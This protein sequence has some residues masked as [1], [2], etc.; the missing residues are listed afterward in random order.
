MSSVQLPEDVILYI[1]TFNAEHR[2]KFKNSLEEMVP[3]AAIVKFNY[4]VSNWNN[5]PDSIRPAF[6]SYITESSHMDSPG[7][8]VKALNKCRC[9]IRHQF[10]KPKDINDR[11]YRKFIDGC[12]PGGCSC[13]CRHAARAVVDQDH[14][15]GYEYDEDDNEG[16][17]QYELYD[18]YEGYGIF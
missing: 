11:Q 9:C 12:S 1:Y 5:I 13:P 17:L 7:D 2:E 18:P 16:P 10:N 6:R 3:K 15:F 8:F 14:D 4:I